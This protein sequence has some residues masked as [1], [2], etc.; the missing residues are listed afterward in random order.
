MR[1]PRTGMLKTETRPT[2]VSKKSPNDRMTPPT[3]NREPRA[4]REKR[5]QLQPSARRRE[6]L[7][8]PL[9]KRAPGLERELPPPLKR[10]PGT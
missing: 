1:G 5:V 4:Q 7:L 9:P 6:R 8:R 2:I 3:V 10:T